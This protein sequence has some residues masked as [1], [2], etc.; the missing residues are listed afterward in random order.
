MKN[1]L[2]EYALKGAALGFLGLML[3]VALFSQGCNA[4]RK[5]VAQKGRTNEVGL[6]KGRSNGQKRELNDYY[7]GIQ[8]KNYQNKD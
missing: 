1:L 2:K 8:H 7:N 6:Q 3:L 4:D 5:V